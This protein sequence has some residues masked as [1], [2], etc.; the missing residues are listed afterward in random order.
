MPVCHDDGSERESYDEADES[1]EGAPYGEREK[2]N[3]WVHTH[4]LAHNLRSNNHVDNDLDDGEDGECRDE[5]H[6]EVLTRVSR[7]E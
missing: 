2:E 6:P 3:G 5:Y 1:E 4:R 7:L